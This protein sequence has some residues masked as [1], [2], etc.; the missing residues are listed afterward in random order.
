[1][2]EEEVDSRTEILRRIRGPAE[3]EILDPEPFIGGIAGLDPVGSA[4][5]KRGTVV[6]PPLPAPLLKEASY[7]GAPGVLRIRVAVGHLE[8]PELD[9]G[10]D[11]GVDSAPHKQGSLGKVYCSRR[12]G[13]G[14]HVALAVVR[15]Q[16]GGLG[17]GNLQGFG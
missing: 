7:G 1:V 2:A 8:P 16:L 5:F 14:W 9:N 12:K 11:I 3:K 13:R 10:R 17:Q 6:L 4:V 15:E